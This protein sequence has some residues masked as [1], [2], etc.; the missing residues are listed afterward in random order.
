MQITSSSTPRC[1]RRADSGV[2][3][4]ALTPR[5]DTTSMG[6]ESTTSPP[7]RA[8]SES[9]SGVH[10]AEEREV[11]V[12]IRP[13]LACK[14][15]AKPPQP[16][17][18]EEPYGRCTNMRMSSFACGGANSSATLPPQRSQPEQKFDYSQHCSTMPLPNGHFNPPQSQQNPSAVYAT[19][20][21][22]MTQS[23][24]AA[25]NMSSFKTPLYANSGVAM[26]GHNNAPPPLPPHPTHTTLPNGVRYSNPNILRRLPPHVK[27]AESPYGHLGL[28]AGHHAF[29]KPGYENTLL[30]STIPEDRDSANYS[31]SS[32]QD[33]LYA[34][35]NPLH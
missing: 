19:S 14:P 23:L 22:C 31:M 32:D 24:N 26:S 12:V 2:P 4:E 7:E 6:T 27:G 25:S 16:A 10:S 21:H 8:P 30:N 28:G 9:S 17:I 20:T 3:Q 1:L 34:T 13:R 33:C 11:E 18:Q 29:T 35:A 5:S 15:P